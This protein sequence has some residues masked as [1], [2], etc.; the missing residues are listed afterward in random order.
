M[1]KSA[2]VAAPSLNAATQ[3]QRHLCLLEFDHA[4]QA[5]RTKQF[6]AAASLFCLAVLTTSLPAQ[7]KTAS[8][9]AP[10]D[11]LAQDLKLLQGTW[12]LVH[13]SA[14]Q[15]APTVRSIKRIEG[16]RETLRRYNVTTGA[17]THEHSVDFVLTTSGAV[18]VF[19]F[20]AV[21]GDPKQGQSFVY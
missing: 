17:L 19:T 4:G 8:D 20:Y 6:L 21:G 18:R 2:A 1:K 13:A 9:K 16:Q 7:E 15:G 10:I 12:E 14:G 5:M 11:V 3:P